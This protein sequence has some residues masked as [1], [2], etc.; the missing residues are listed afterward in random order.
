MHAKLTACGKRLIGAV[1]LSVLLVLVTTPGFAQNALRRGAVIQPVALAE[2]GDL[3]LG[4]GAGYEADVNVP[5]LSIEGD[6]ARIGILQLSWAVGD[7]VLLEVWGDAYR[8]LT[9]DSMGSAPP[10]EPDEGVADGKSTGAGDFGAVITFLVFGGEQGF[11]I[12]GRLGFNIPDSNQAEGLGTNTTNIGMSLLGSYGR[13]PFLITGDVGIG[14]LEAPLEN[15]EQNDVIIYSAEVLYSIA[16]AQTLRAYAS[17]G[18]RAS[19]RGEVPVGTEDLG[20]VGIGADYRFSRWRLD[21]A[22]LVGYAGN[23]PSWGVTAGVALLF[24]N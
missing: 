12:G 16:G 23:S 15:F 10:V 22:G 17:I 2:K 21:A 8:A 13:G 18:G 5:L 9:V 7:R 1:L 24:G 4:F 11:G 19:T 14:I 6:L 20:V 3:L